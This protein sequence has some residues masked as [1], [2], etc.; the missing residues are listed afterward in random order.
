[1]F[2]CAGSLILCEVFL[3]CDDIQ[4]CRYIDGLF[5]ILLSQNISE[6]SSQKLYAKSS[7]SLRISLNTRTC[8]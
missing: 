3:L 8:L 2:I 7:D 6:A 4:S 1:M 5:K